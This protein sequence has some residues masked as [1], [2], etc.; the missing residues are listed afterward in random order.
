MNRRQFLTGA[1][2]VGV[3]GAAGCTDFVETQE[4]DE[5]GNGARGGESGGGNG[6]GEPPVVEDRPD[7]VYVPT[8]R[9]GMEMVGTGEA[10]DYTVGLTYSFPHRFW[11]VTGTETERVEVRAEDDVHL[12][13][14]V[15]D[16]ETET[17][18]PVGAGLSMEIER[19]GEFVAEKSPWPMLSQS[20]GFHFGDNFSLDGDGTYTVRVGIGGTDLARFG[21]FAGR[22]EERATAEIEFAYSAEERDRIPVERFEDRQGERGALEPMEMN[23]L[24]TSVLPAPEDLP[25]RVVGE[26]ESGDARF[27]VGA[28]ESPPFVEEGAYLYVSPR[29]PYNRV[30]LPMASLSFRQARDG[31]TIAEGSLREALEPSAGHHYG[32]PVDGIESGDSLTVAV[33]SPPQASRHEG[34]ETAFLE[35]PDVEATVE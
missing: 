16:G 9:E 13:A 6:G 23:M 5:D 21:D 1:A 27:V 30:P 33:D 35:M 29:T 14:T 11:V 19:D 12:M 28:V 31:E 10:G 15:W 34:F 18:L 7:A 3:G 22:F 26:G 25:G 20:M 32:A 4:V 8:H 24:P 17:V 2:A